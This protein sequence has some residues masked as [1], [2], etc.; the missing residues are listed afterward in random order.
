MRSHPTDDWLRP[1][2]KRLTDADQLDLNPVPPGTNRPLDRLLKADLG[3][4]S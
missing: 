2:P 1:R 4:G 3:S